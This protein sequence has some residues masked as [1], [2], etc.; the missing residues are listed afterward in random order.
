MRQKS[1]LKNLI[2]LAA[3]AT[4]SGLSLVGCAN[5]GGS[6]PI[7]SD[8]GMVGKPPPGSVDA[9]VPIDDD[10]GLQKDNAPKP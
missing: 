2:A 8:A 7:D 6:V 4:I 10:V 3:L 1:S 5:Y 9:S